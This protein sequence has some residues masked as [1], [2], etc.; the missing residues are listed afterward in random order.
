MVH[1][2]VIVGGSFLNILALAVSLAF[3]VTLLLPHKIHAMINGVILLAIGITHLLYE[4]L[5]IEFDVRGSPILLFVIVFVVAA[6][7]KELIAESIKEKG[8]AM[9]GLTFMAGIILIILVLIPELYHAGALGFNLP[10]YPFLVNAI[11]YLFAGVVAII[12][13]FLQKAH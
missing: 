11:I 12:A 8:K 6:T 2:A 1:E 5:I 3:I 13:P 9:K 4:L 10:D 7:A